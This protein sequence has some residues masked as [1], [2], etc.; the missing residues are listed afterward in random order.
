M[1]A[2]AGGIL[3]IKNTTGISNFDSSDANWESWRMRFEAQAGLANMVTHLDVAAEQSFF[4]RH[5]G[6][7]DNSLLISNT[8]HAL[9]ITKC[10]GKSRWL[11]NVR[12]LKHGV[13]QTRVRG[14]RWK[15]HN[16]ALK[17][18]PQPTCQMGKMHSEGRDLGDMLVS[19]EKDVAQYRVAAGTD[20]QQAV[21]VATVMEHAPAAYR[22]LLQVVPLANRETYQAL[23]A[24]VREWTLAQRTYDDL[25]RHTT[26]DT[27]VPMD[28]RQVNGTRKKG[29]KGRE[30]KER[31][32]ARARETTVK[33]RRDDSY[34]AGEREY[35]G[36]WGH[37][38]APCRGLKRDQGGRPSAAAAQAAAT[39]IEV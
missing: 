1:S 15:S 18:H 4:V 25:G 21:Q 20:F 36:K 8:V 2:D 37:K 23:R 28:I 3:D 32:K 31:R 27:S 6:L 30:G 7:Y 22:D 17:R 11:L 19:W 5:D 29:K 38:K 33:R 10:E 13:P 39:E 9:L 26:P 16:S 34:F 14:Q 35:C 24:Y 12:A